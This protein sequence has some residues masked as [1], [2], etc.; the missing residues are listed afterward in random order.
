MPKPKVVSFEKALKKLG[1]GKKPHLLLGN[2]FSRACRDDIFSYEALYE[3][4]ELSGLSKDARKA[5]TALGTTDFEQVMRM[6]KQASKLAKEY[7]RKNLA[8][9]LSEH[10]DEI[11]EV[12]VRT[13]ADNHPSRP[14][15]VSRDQYQACKEFLSRFN[16]VYTLNYDLLLYWA[17]MQDEIEPAVECDDGFRQPDDGPEDYVTWEVQKTNSQ[18]IHYLHGALHIYDAGAELQKYTWSNTQ[19]ALIDQ[20]RAALKADK[21]PLFVSEGT[22]ESKLDRIQHSGYLNRSYRSFANL[23][24][25][26]LIFGMSMAQND[27][28]ILRLLDRGKFKQI[29]IGLFGPAD[30]AGNKRIIAR[31][32][33]FGTKRK[34]GAP[35]LLYFDAASAAV[36][37]A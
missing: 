35:D 25:S 10:A 21:Y 2:G 6:L 20:I 33:D 32:A 17:V 11:R 27:E 18:S 4:A 23:G 22:A 8:R 26:L 14:H 30:S 34:G 15:D 3:Q 29:A 36:W 31:A 13:I 5:F 7:G 28:H 24:G 9:I 12:L 37:G 16:D 1:D 19:I